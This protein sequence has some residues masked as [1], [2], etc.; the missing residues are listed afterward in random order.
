MKNLSIK[1]QKYR[2]NQNKEATLL[3]PPFAQKGKENYIEEKRTH[4][5]TTKPKLSFIKE[6]WK[7][8][9]VKTRAN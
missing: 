8:I 2:K 5:A 3:A 4:K 7:N 1:A 9:L 6:V